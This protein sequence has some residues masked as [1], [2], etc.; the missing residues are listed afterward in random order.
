MPSPRIR[1]FTI[2][3][4]F[5][6][7][8]LMMIFFLW[9]A[10]PCL[11]P[12]TRP[13]IMLGFPLQG[14]TVVIDP[15]HGGIDSG[16]TS[17]R[18]EEKNITLAISQELVKLLKQAGATSILTRCR[19]EDISYLFPGETSSRYQRDI[20]ARVK[21]INESGADLFVSIHIDSC[22][23]P[24]IRGAI[25]FYNQKH[26]KNKLLAETIQKH[27]NPAVNTNVQPGEYVHQDIKEG[28][29]YI[30]N[31]TEVPGVI[32]EVAFMTNP[33]DR[34]LIVQK[35]HQVRIAQS[36]FMGILEYLHIHDQEQGER[37]ELEQEQE[38]E[39]QH[40]QNRS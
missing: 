3:L 28:S 40:E 1:L 20:K 8:A 5:A 35:S 34:E 27:L 16:V 13:V 7:A 21:I 10:L 33:T 25:A 31:E 23:D 32:M 30:L 37:Q 26:P 6:G 19:D 12:P 15:G 38:Q 22:T 29:Y 17:D 2:P 36:L 39:Q 9:T 14:A 11:F 18:I 4:R 24:S